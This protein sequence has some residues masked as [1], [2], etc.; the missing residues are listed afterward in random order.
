M[1]TAESKRDLIDALE[2]R[3]VEMAIHVLYEKNYL[4]LR[5]NGVIFILRFEND[6]FKVHTRTEELI[7]LGESTELKLN[8]RQR[9]ILSGAIKYKLEHLNDDSITCSKLTEILG[10]ENTQKTIN[11]LVRSR[12]TL[13]SKGCELVEYLI[14]K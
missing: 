8:K 3:E 7:K 12:N 1:I 11:G 6:E 13:I 4:E 10:Y 14:T 5:N 2:N 9:E